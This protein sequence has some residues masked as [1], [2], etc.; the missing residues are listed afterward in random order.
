MTGAALASLAARRARA[1]IACLAV[2]ALGLALTAAGGMRV[3]ALT[4]GIYLLMHASLGAAAVLLTL[5]FVARAGPGRGADRAAILHGLALAALVGL[6]P[7]SGFLGSVAL[8]RALG[9]DALAVWTLVLSSM[10]VGL[11]AIVQ[12]WRRVESAPCAGG[13]APH[14][15]EFAAAA[16]VTLLLALGVAAG[17]ALEFAN[18]A[19][20]QLL[21]RAAYVTAVAAVR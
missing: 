8:L 18:A 11:I 13:D 17:P 3:A 9:P 4:A 20:R 15:G 2:L 16:A 6:P 12:A 5:E 10:L 19:A 21:D 14:S 1:L 7:L